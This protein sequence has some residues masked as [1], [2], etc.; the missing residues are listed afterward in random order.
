MNATTQNAAP[1][2][3]ENVANATAVKK[4][5]AFYN[6][7]A[8]G[9]TGT[10]VSL[11]INTVTTAGAP[12]FDGSIGGQRVAIRI[13]NAA[14]GSFLAITK[15]LKAEEVGADGYKEVQIGTA[16]LI[17]ND[18]AIPVLAIKMNDNKDQTV[19]A[20]VS[21]KAPQELLIAAGLNMTILAEKKAAY[22]AAKAA[23]AEAQVH[24]AEEEAVAA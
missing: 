6:K 5:E 18:R 12:D 22:E 2:I 24:A 11:W 10:V 17:V 13:R 3:N 19:W 4:I 21:L 8:E 23:K 1:S 14:K 20:N 15:S 16:N 9:K 7:P